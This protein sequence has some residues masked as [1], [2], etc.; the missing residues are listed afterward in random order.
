MLGFGIVLLWG[1]L[2]GKVIV[3]IQPGAGL[4]AVMEGFGGKGRILT[5]EQG[6]II[7]LRFHPAVLRHGRL[8]GCV[9]I[10]GGCP[11]G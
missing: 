7:A 4:K 11:A 8:A 1:L 10:E 3:G 5:D 6:Y 9:A 2:L